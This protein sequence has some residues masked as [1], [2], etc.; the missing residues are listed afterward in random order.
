MGVYYTSD[1][2]GLHLKVA[3]TRGFEDETEYTGWIIDQYAQQ[4]KKGDQLWILGDLT[5][6]ATTKE[7]IVLSMLREF[8][9]GRSLHFIAGNHD[10]VHPGNNRNSHNRLKAFYETFDS[11]QLFARRKIAGESVM[12][13]HFPYEGDRDEERFE[14]YRLRDSGRWLLH[15][16]LHSEHIFNNNQDKS[17]HIGWDTWNKLVDLEEIAEIINNE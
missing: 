16:H 11:V 7:D 9:P 8:L 2:H 3:Q 13:S 5:I 14:E 10:S 6:G 15:G 1:T 4:T 17:I 12:L